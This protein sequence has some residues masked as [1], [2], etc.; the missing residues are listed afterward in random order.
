MCKSWLGIDAI[1]RINVD[2]KFELIILNVRFMEYEEWKQIPPMAQ[3]LEWQSSLNVLPIGEILTAIPISFTD[4]R[5]CVRRCVI[6]YFFSSFRF[7]ILY[8]SRTWHTGLNWHNEINTYIFV[9]V[10]V[11][12]FFFLFFHAMYDALHRAPKNLH[13]RSTMC[14]IRMHIREV[15]VG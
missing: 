7:D 11:S 6:F 3:W 10:Y 9:H 5:P 13:A 8:C 14:G 1:Y 12:V 15:C 2:Q 4:H